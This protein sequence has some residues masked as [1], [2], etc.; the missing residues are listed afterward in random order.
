LHTVVIVPYKPAKRCTN[1][2]FE[3]YSSYVN[4]NHIATC[5]VCKYLYWQTEQKRLKKQFLDQAE[6]NQVL[7]QAEPFTWIFAVNCSETT[8]IQWGAIAAESLG[9]GVYLLQSA[10][11]L[12][13]VVIEKLSS[14]TENYWIAILGQQKTCQQAFRQI[15]KLPVT[16]RERNDIIKVCRLFTKHLSYR[17]HP[18]GAGIYED[19]RRN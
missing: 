15:Q 1:T 6:F 4:V 9:Q 3:H 18:K 13:L 16:K 19:S 10:N 17:N 2:I 5:L 12:G 11:R 14:P 8:L 7:S